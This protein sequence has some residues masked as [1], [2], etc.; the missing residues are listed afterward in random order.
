MKQAAIYILLFFIS[1]ANYDLPG[2]AEK[3]VN[4]AIHKSWPSKEVKSS[5]I[6]LS[7]KT[8]KTEKIG[9]KTYELRANSEQ[10]GYMVLNKAPS[11]SR[12]FDYM[13]L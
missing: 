8:N 12:T 5:S 3:K 6:S 2:Y 7:K 13:I 1:G 4:K 11:K 9:F 10:L